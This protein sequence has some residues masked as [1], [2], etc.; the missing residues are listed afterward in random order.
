M[1]SLQTNINAMER[2]MQ[3]YSEKQEMDRNVNEASMVMKDIR[4]GDAS[5]PDP[6]FKKF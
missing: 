2:S 3:A 5:I 6:T 1:Q 4:A